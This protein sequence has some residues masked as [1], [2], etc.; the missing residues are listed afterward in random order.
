MLSPFHNKE[1]GY[2]ILFSTLILIFIAI[3]L[4]V[5]VS[6]SGYLARFNILNSSA[7]ESSYALASACAEQALLSLATTNTYTGNQ[8]VSVGS[9]TC[10]IYAIQSQ[11]G[12]TIITTKGSSQN[13][14]TNLKITVTQ[15]TPITIV[16]W[17]EIPIL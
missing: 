8:T 5:S 10:Q 12:Q 13:T 6:Y 4:V 9:S 1:S 7:K 14:T 3:T 15:T 2:I 11:S 17:E 16:S